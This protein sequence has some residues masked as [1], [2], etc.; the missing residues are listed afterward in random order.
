VLDTTWYVFLIMFNFQGPV[1]VRF[2]C[3]RCSCHVDDTSLLFSLVSNNILPCTPVG[4]FNRAFMA[5]VVQNKMD[6]AEMG[7]LAS[8]SD[9]AF[10]GYLLSMAA[11]YHL[12]GL[13]SKDFLAKE[14][15]QVLKVRSFITAQA[16]ILSFIDGEEDPTR[17]PKK[18][19]CFFCPPKNSSAKMQVA[20]DGMFSAR[21]KYHGQDNSC[22]T[23][24]WQGSYYLG[25]EYEDR[26]R[27][28]KAS[29]LERRGKKG[30]KARIEASCT[31][32]H[33]CDHVNTANGPRNTASREETSGIFATTCRH[34]HAKNVV[35]ITDGGEK[36]S[37][38]MVALGSIIHESECPIQIGYDISCSLEP[39]TANAPD[40]EC[41]QAIIKHSF[42]FV[43][44]ALH[45][46]GHKSECFFKYSP[47]W[48]P[49]TG[50][51]KFEMP[52][53]LWSRM[54]GFIA[55]MQ[56]MSTP[57]KQELI[58]RLLH[59]INENSRITYARALPKKFEVARREYIESTEALIGFRKSKA[60]IEDMRAIFRE[61]AMKGPSKAAK[62]QAD[63]LHYATLIDL[64]V[65]AEAEL[66]D[67]KFPAD[68][69]VD[70]VDDVDNILG[71]NSRVSVEDDSEFSD[72]VDDGPTLSLLERKFEDAK[73]ELQMFEK[74]KRSNNIWTIGMDGDNKSVC[75]HPE[76]LALKLGGAL[77]VELLL[78]DQLCQA[79]YLYNR[80]KSKLRVHSGTKAAGE[81]GKK[82]LKLS[83]QRR[84]RLDA[85]NRVSQTRTTIA[86]IDNEKSAFW[87]S[88]S[89]DPEQY[90]MITTLCAMESARD[91]LIYLKEAV[92][93]FRF[94]V[95]AVLTAAGDYIRDIIDT[96][97]SATAVER[98]KLQCVIE[99]RRR[100][101]ENLTILENLDSIIPTINVL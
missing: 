82:L 89:C 14:F 38:A 55:P 59:G 35:D 52:E 60:A 80:M 27:E 7:A 57:N 101:M 50:Y 49:L 69:D 83:R 26:L 29:D 61:K 86:D 70:D 43:I 44:G 4:P 97:G 88:S 37:Y 98:G 5:N 51:C 25:R 1:K 21:Q 81:A 94:H 73:R 95:N 11:R 71:S 56:H 28:L 36:L 54:Q 96:R 19:E 31:G 32:N 87:S 3:E 18:M 65:V 40:N 62:G 45:A 75:S 10:A 39:Y 92:G 76:Y 22:G 67:F 2:R 85:Y 79:S 90:E 42:G 34:Y 99:F 47:L 33:A 72:G 48:V 16:G 91:E 64:F 6:L 84:N 93:N 30:K 15:R 23:N 17:K 53:W 63:K 77:E 100:E 58:S 9:Y 78:K 74:N 46:Y 41:R 8:I 12:Q 20:I 66:Y 13:I 68:N 24:R